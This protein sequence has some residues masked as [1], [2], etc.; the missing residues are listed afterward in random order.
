MIKLSIHCLFCLE[1]GKSSRYKSHTQMLFILILSSVQILISAENIQLKTIHKELEETILSSNN[2]KLSA[3]SY[4][5]E[6]V[7]YNQLL[8]YLESKLP[9]PISLINQLR[10]YNI[11]KNMLNKIHSYNILRRELHGK[12]IDNEIDTAKY[13]EVLSKKFQSLFKSVTQEE[14]KNFLNLI[15]YLKM[16]NFDNKKLYDTLHNGNDLLKLIND[17]KIKYLP[18]MNTDKKLPDL[19]TNN[20]VNNEIKKILIQYKISSKDLYNKLINKIDPVLLED[21]Y[22]NTQL[23]EPDNK[24]EI[25]DIGNNPYNLLRSRIQELTSFN[26]K[27][28]I[29][30]LD[31]PLPK[32]ET[33]Q[34]VQ[35]EL[36]NTK[37]KQIDKSLD[38]YIKDLRLLNEIEKERDHI[39]NTKID[40][41]VY[42][43]KEIQKIGILH[44]Q[45]N[46]IAELVGLYLVL[47]EV[48]STSSNQLKRLPHIKKSKETLQQ[49]HMEA[50]RL[51]NYLMNKNV[52]ESLTKVQNIVKEHKDLEKLDG[53]NN[54]I[55]EMDMS[56]FENN[57]DTKIN[58]E[59]LFSAL[60]NKHKPIKLAQKNHYAINGNELFGALR[61]KKPE[62]IIKDKVEY[63]I[64][65]NDMLNLL[66][67]TNDKVKIDIDNRADPIIN[68]NIRTLD[69]KEKEPSL[70]AHKIDKNYANQ[71]ELVDG[72]IL[73]NLLKK[74]HFARKEKC[75][76]NNNDGVNKIKE[77]DLN[78]HKVEKNNANQG[79]LVNG[80]ILYNLLKQDHFVK[81]E[82]GIDNNN[83]EVN[84]IRGQ[85]LYNI[86]NPNIETKINTK[87]INFDKF[88]QKLF[89]EFSKHN[90]GTLDASTPKM[91]STKYYGKIKML[92][93][94]I[95]L[96]WISTIRRKIT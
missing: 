54:E 53:L 86:L 75:I 36:K 82:N 25:K 46:P 78:A 83:D 59:T 48:L 40:E 49:S 44:I 93:F 35:T 50:G 65:G 7:A 43:N 13:S 2:S 12:L 89:N 17:K 14:K 41:L 1:R 57:K 23:V 91:T 72:R 37:K 71:G 66:H 9:I 77:Q 22:K 19:F 81:K 32:V 58:G 15:N 31:E 42:P 45:R 87:N 52:K 11:N 20:K 24:I 34:N 74:D 38:K 61:K 28:R 79:E 6:L 80:N 26:K 63:K 64:H 73:Y 8:P 16:F 85:D 70:N 27:P 51:Y 30:P 5:N 84:Q 18:F 88:Y 94:L 92:K 95:Y 4:N 56:P 90:S 39:I 69:E 33:N 3:S 60:K 68:E 10:K 76:E 96:H 55:N 62:H 67:K 47:N 21:M 29:I